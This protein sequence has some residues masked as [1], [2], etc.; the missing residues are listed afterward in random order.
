MESNLLHVGST[1]FLGLLLHESIDC[2]QAIGIRFYF[3]CKA[4]N[5]DNLLGTDKYRIHHLS[6]PKELSVAMTSVGFG[7]DALNCCLFGAHHP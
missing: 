1:I 4:L 2:N 6:Y 7:K 5:Q 3:F